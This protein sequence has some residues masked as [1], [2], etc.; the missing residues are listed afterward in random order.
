ME[1]SYKETLRYVLEVFYLA[2]KSLWFWSLDN[3]N[4][5]GEKLGNN[6]VTNL[7]YATLNTL[8][9]VIIEDL[10]KNTEKHG[11]D[12]Q[13]FT[14]FEL[15]L[16]DAQLLDLKTH[17]K[18]VVRVP[19]NSTGMNGKGF[20]FKDMNGV[21]LTKVRFFVPGATS[22]TNI[23]RV[24]LLHM[25]Q[26]TIVDVNNVE[27]DF[28]HEKIRTHFQYRLDLAPKFPEDTDGT[29]D[30]DIGKET[31]SDYALVGPFTTWHVEVGSP[32]G[33]AVVDLGGVNKA[34]FSFHGYYYSK[35]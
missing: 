21:R 26:E 6:V 23:V 28:Q 33:A 12:M 27:H 3:R 1:R 15:P 16:D 13:K 10:Q 32:D 30:G 11:Q 20:C 18:T 9:G 17:G 25:G 24:T 2:Q 14:G 22:T 7:T 8:K 31:G 34:Y 4:Y 19:T 5:L 35:R 29:I